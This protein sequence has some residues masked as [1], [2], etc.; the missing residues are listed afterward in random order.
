M[1]TIESTIRISAPV[2]A[3]Y[4]I[5]Q[6]NESFPEFMEDVVSLEIIERDGAKVTSDWVGLISA[7]AMKVKWRQEDVWNDEER[8]CD[9]RQVKGDFDEMA[10]SWEFIEED[11]GTKFVSRMDY[12]YKVPGLGPLVAKV[13]HGL[14]TKNVESAMAAIKDRAESQSA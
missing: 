13:V 3:V 1:P 6:D 7:F 8:R 12:V 4:A 14:V 5:A 2:D 10:G 9:Y 11:G